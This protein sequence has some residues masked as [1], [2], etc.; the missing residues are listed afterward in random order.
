MPEANPRLSVI[1]ASYNADDTIAACLDSLRRQET[2][3]PFEIL[4]VESSGDGTAELIRR[5]YPDVRVIESSRRLHCGEARNRALEVARADLI[6][7]LDADC[8]VESGW[9]DKVLEA[10]RGDSL[11]VGGVIDNAA[12]GSSVGWAYYFC[13]FSLWLPCRRPRRVPEMAGCGLSFKR[14]A[15][16]RYG[17]FLEGTYSS[18]TAFQWK[19]RDDGHTVLLAPEIRIYHRGPSSLRRLLAHT[20]EHRRAYARV[21]CRERRLGRSR[22]AVAMLLLPVTPL[23][24][25]GAVLL[26][27]RRCPRY[28]PRYLLC[29][30]TLLLGYGARSLGELAGYLRP[31]GGDGGC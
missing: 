21:R 19:T 5:R 31:G 4:L 12:R 24:L 9:V 29:A 6:A 22:R 17:P 10:H 27:L 1:I 15:F 18:D 14:A 7:F 11:L 28:L 13:E 30:P 25:M 23:L 3:E 26:R 20:F 16:D 8:F 2:G